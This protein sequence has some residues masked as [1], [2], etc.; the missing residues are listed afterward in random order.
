[1]DRREEYLRLMAKGDADRKNGRY[2]AATRA[3]RKA[4]KLFDSQEIEK[5]LN[6]NAYEQLLAQ[7]R[8]Y[9][10]IDNWNAARAKL[11]SAVKIHETPEATQ[12]LN[13]VTRK[14]AESNE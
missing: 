7:A 14:L 12:L 2:G 3:Y 5:R 10:Q 9:I 13:D 1:V 8:H 4:Q 6:D 11:M